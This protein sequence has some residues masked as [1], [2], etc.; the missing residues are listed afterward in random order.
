MKFTLKQKQY[1]DTA[2]G[3]PLLY[4]NKLF[5]LFFGKILRRNHTLEITPEKIIV[6][7]MLGWGSIIMASD[8][9]ISIKNKYPSASFEII[10][11]ASIA[12]GVIALRLFDKVHIVKDVTYIKTIVSSLQIISTFWKHTCWVIDLEVYS[13]LSSLLSLWTLAINR[14]GFSFDAVLFRKNIN[15]H[16]VY[17][18]NV[19]QVAENYKRMAVS[20]GV[21]EFTSYIIKGYEQRTSAMCYEYI[22]INNTCSELSQERL[23]TEK[24]LLELCIWI[25]ANTTY[26]IALL[27]APSDKN[28]IQHFINNNALQ[29]VENFCGLLS[30]EKYFHFLHHQCKLIITVDSAPL[31]IAQKINVPSLSIWGPTTYQ[32]RIKV[33]SIN[34]VISHQVSCSPCAHY[35]GELPCKGNN[36]CIKDISLQEIVGTLQSML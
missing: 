4:I 29:N 1:I 19:V 16:N 13:K 5:A 12:E 28:H 30:I 14:F 15:T 8:S 11:S 26:K 10:C 31:H 17:F 22:A 35:V 21:T 32:S 3:L 20:L 36:F 27:G 7:K 34:K 9:L 25:A 33:D 6:I 18:N 2:I 23:L 24:Q